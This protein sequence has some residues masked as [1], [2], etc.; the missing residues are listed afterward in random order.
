MDLAANEKHLDQAVSDLV[1]GYGE[2]FYLLAKRFL[3]ERGNH[4][5]DARKL[6]ESIARSSHSLSSFFCKKD[7]QLRN[8]KAHRRKLFEIYFR[9]LEHVGCAETSTEMGLFRQD[10]LFGIGCLFFAWVMPC[11]ATLLQSLT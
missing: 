6:S 8:G 9:V 7:D 10:A 5:A 2:R 1:V 3:D 4:P 11:S